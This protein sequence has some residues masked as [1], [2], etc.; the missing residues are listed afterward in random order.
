MGIEPVLEKQQLAA[1]QSQVNVG[2]ESGS[3][4]ASQSVPQFWQ[5]VSIGDH[6][7]RPW[8]QRSEP[9]APAACDFEVSMGPTSGRRSLSLV[10]NLP[11]GRCQGQHPQHPGPRHSFTDEMENAK[12]P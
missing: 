4:H 5:L 8:P 9:Q 7:H 11:S 6:Q 12:E 2:N 1:R 10:E 3:E